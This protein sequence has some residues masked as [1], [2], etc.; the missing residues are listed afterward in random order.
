MKNAKIQALV[1][2]S[3]RVIATALVGTIT[4]KNRKTAT[5]GML[6]EKGQRLMEFDAQHLDDYQSLTAEKVHERVN[7]ILKTAAIAREVKL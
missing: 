6:P 1:D 5:A 4:L 2:V 7:A 3:G